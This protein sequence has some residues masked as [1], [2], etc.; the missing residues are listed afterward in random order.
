MNS[1]DIE[2][3][4]ELLSDE[5]GVYVGR[6]RSIFDKYKNKAALYIGKVNET[7]KQ[8]QSH[9]DKRVLLDSISPHAIFICGMRGSGKS[10]TLGVI[11]EE[12]AMKNDGVGILIIDP[13][14]I[15][16]S[17]KQKNR[18]ANEGEMLKRW[19]LK[20]TGINNVKVFIPKDYAN[21]AP[22]ETWDDLFKIKP[23]ELRV[24]D[25]CLTFDIERFDTMG[26]LIERVIEKTKTGYTTTEGKRVQGVGEDYGIEDLIKTIE[27]EESIYS[28]E[29][30]FKENTRRA[31]NARLTG[32][33]QWGIFDKNGTK[34]N[35]LSKRG[36]VS[37][38]DV[39]F[40]EDNVR[41]LVVGL[42]SRNILNTRKV[43]SR[44]EAMGDINLI[45][46]VPVTWLMI[47]E[48]HILVPRGGKATAA[49]DSLIEYVR[50]GRQPGCSIVLATQQPS[51]IDSRILSQVDLL[52]CHKLV[53]QDDI[54]AVLQRMPSEIPN[55]LSDFR[56]IRSLPIGS[57]IIGD[58]EESTSRAFF[59]SVR[60][61]ISQHE[62]R[63][64][65]PMFEIDPDLMK[66]NIKNLIL[67]KYRQNRPL[68]EMEEVVNIANQEYKLKF[69]FEDIIEEL[70]IDGEF[71]AI[72]E[73][74]QD[75]G[76]KRS[77][78]D[79]PR[80]SEENSLED[81]E[82]IEGYGTKY[83]EEEKIL[84]RSTKI[85][86]VVSSKIDYDQIKEI[87]MKHKKKLSFRSEEITE[88]YPIYYPI[89]MVF[90]DYMPKKGNYKSMSCF[91]D[92]ITGELLIWDGKVS[93]TVGFSENYK[94]RPDERWLLDYIIK[95]NSLTITDI[96][97]E[98]GF[99]P[100]KVH[101]ILSN[102]ETKGLIEYKTDGKDIVIKT[103]IKFKLV[104]GFE[105]KKLKK[106]DISLKNKEVSGKIIDSLISK[107]DVMKGIESL[108]NAKIWKTEEI[109]LP[110]WL[111][112]YR[113]SKGKERREI[114]DTFK[115]EKDDNIRDIVLM[116]V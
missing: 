83:I 91:F 8:W 92:G 28:R 56:F 84:F 61:R 4:L 55:K 108:G 22:K 30:G 27:N 45:G 25:W 39:S 9:L 16:W 73:E 110:Y 109:Y 98:T 48:A 75:Y 15:F 19:G 99:T 52:I 20:P 32:A 81:L 46:N 94:L 72:N 80:V 66:T 11:V 5:E 114:F 76:S 18:M 106:V 12:M 113:N 58:K 93:R 36:Q 82:L 102:L 77:P 26:L 14:G 86:P 44:H 107:N 53:Y 37:V 21:K 95:K 1:I 68:S 40:L 89:T 49:T 43:I 70:R 85:L 74:Q 6:K 57:A 54:K 71:E 96:K 69:S 13:M 59:I 34:L 105:D 24:E 64:R 33:I 90:F 2:E 115:G 112:V 97:K 104:K 101:S 10:Y 38:I 79:L 60:P 50:Q 29:D 62:G 63:E 42:L 7:S 31:L 41:A 100:N 67:E 111:V 17:M 78:I 47:D 87:A 65:Q 103:K 116:R 3:R 35:D 51:A 23:S 88:I